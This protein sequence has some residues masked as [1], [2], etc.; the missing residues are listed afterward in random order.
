MPFGTLLMGGGQGGGSFTVLTG[1][2]HMPHQLTL[3][4]DS[5]REALHQTHD[6]RVKQPHVQVVTAQQATE[7]G[8]VNDPTTLLIQIP[9]HLVQQA[10]VSNNKP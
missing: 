8:E 9:K 10:A 5:R 6:V 1:F 4:V 7:L 2:A 3:G